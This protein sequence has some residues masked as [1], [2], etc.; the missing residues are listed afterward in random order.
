[1]Q[2]NL[3]EDVADDFDGLALSVLL[4][5]VVGDENR[6]HA[7][8]GEEGVHGGLDLLGVAMALRLPPGAPAPV[9]FPPRGIV[10]V[11]LEEG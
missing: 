4:A 10:S 2:S 3:L 6:L 1:M 9:R 7:G 11:L 5:S 8:D